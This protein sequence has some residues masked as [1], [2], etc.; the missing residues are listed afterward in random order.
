MPQHKQSGCTVLFTR[1]KSTKMCQAF[2]I[3][4][5]VVSKFASKVGVAKNMKDVLCKWT[6]QEKNV[7]FHQNFLT[8]SFF[9]IPG[10]F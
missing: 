8:L 9:N 3:F 7:K 5:L 6:P 2:S 1:H 10:I 4:S